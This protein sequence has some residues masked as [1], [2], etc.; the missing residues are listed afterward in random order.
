MG[1]ESIYL[2][3][4]TAE[5]EPHTED[6]PPDGLVDLTSYPLPPIVRALIV[7]VAYFLTARL[8]AVVVFPTL[9]ASA[10]WLPN[11]IVLAGLAL[12]SRRHWWL[13][14]LAALIA[15]FLA[16]P[17]VSSADLLTTSIDYLANV[18]T[19]L[20]GAFALDTLAPAPRRLDLLRPAMVLAVFCGLLAPFLASVLVAAAF[21][22][23]HLDTRWV[24]IVLARTLTNGFAVV[25]IVPLIFHYA[26]RQHPPRRKIEAG[27]VAEACVLFCGLAAAAAIIFI[28]AQTG[29]RYLPLWL[30]CPSPLLLWAALRFGMP[31]L[32]ASTL[33]IGTLSIWSEAGALSNIPPEGITQNILSLISLLLVT[34][35]PLLLLSA[36]LEERSAVATESSVSHSKFRLLFDCNVVPT[37][38]W[39]AEGQIADANPA[40]LELTG[41]TRAEL[42]RGRLRFQDLIAGTAYWDAERFA[43]RRAGP[44][45]GPTEAELQ[46]RN[47]ERIAVLASGRHFPL[48]PGE[49]IAYFS[50]LSAAR[51]AET[52]QRESD[53]LHTAVLASLHDQIVVLDQAGI[54]IAAND[55]RLGIAKPAVTTPLER[56]RV[57]D[58]YLKAPIRD[59]KDRVVGAELLEGVRKVLA[60][61]TPRDRLEF[62]V[63]SP[64][65]LVWF[66]ISIEP[67]RRPEGG[68]VITRSEITERKRAT[69]Q[70]N[71]QRQQLAHLSRAA[72]LGELSGAFA[73][74][75]SQ[76]LTSILG[77]AEAVLQLLSRDTP[78]LQE[79][80][81]IMRDIIRDDVRAAEVIQRLRSMLSRGEV[82]REP[83]DLNQVVR[84]MV[85]LARGD[86]MTRNV[87]VSTNLDAGALVL[88]DRVQLQQ[89]VLNL[90]VNACEAMSGISPDERELAIS[91]RF[92]ASRRAF[93]CVVADR[94]CGIAPQD[95]ER[96]FQPFVTTKQRGLGLGLAICRSIVE[97]HGGNLW[98]ENGD[99]RGAV[100]RFTAKAEA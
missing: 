16:Q 24:Q 90:I 79:I 55:S 26:S 9:P 60:G 6:E 46:I 28:A 63:D 69:A 99:S 49:G 15:H 53:F 59:S 78:N 86:L 51:R 95:L 83:V 18:I 30:F 88:G 4:P 50:D 87:S 32:C 42:R 68:A 12:S 66:E 75:L 72:V 37:V 31:G 33:A 17:P 52:K 70:A 44:S 74:E 58:H 85:E 97:A 81:D 20:L 40:F 82:S 19:V 23:L 35:M 76:P 2:S 39:R 73:H 1:R 65:G 92:D 57:G 21:T 71:D 22:L 41:F 84:D 54:V 48:S 47:S 61:L 29:S 45:W 3:G 11:A 43:E 10:L 64:D 89:V 27:R 56:L 93:E 80:R 14:L 98:A 91:T 5:S 36:S 94:G 67:L 38:L 96:I 25:T 77:N 100:F 7:G 62:S 34:L 13:Y 8:G